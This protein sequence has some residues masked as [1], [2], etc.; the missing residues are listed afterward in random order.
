LD[1]KCIEIEK[2]AEVADL[3]DDHPTRRHVENCPRCRNL[4]RSYRKFVLAEPVAGFGID[5]ARKKLDALIDAKV[6]EKRPTT[7]PRSLMSLSSVLHRFLRPVP[8]LATG[9]AAVLVAVA[10]WQSSGPEGIR[11]RNKP[12]PQTATLAPAEV[13]PDGSIALLWVAVS[14]ADSYQ[15]RIY[16]PGLTEIYRH[17]NVAETTVLIDRSLLPSDLPP[18]FD[19]MWRVYALEAGDIIEVSEPG[20]IRTR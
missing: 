6:A 2:I 9:A 3:P 4:L 17:P 10:V 20:S 18:S 1:T 11:L 12:T 8:L 15:V 19:L 5:G 13:R 7:S 16:G 14:G